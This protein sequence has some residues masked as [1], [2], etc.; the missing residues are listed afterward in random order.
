MF[1]HKKNHHNHN[2]NSR[3]CSPISA[4]G[5][6]TDKIPVAP[7]SADI[8]EIERMMIRQT[9]E[10]KF[11]TINYIYL[12]DNN[13]KLK[14]VI[15]VKELFRQ[16]K[17]K[18][19]ADLMAKELITAR[20][21]TSQERVSY[22]AMKNNIK[23]VPIIDKDDALLGVVSNDVITSIVY[24]ETNED[25]LRF[26]GIHRPRAMIDNVLELSTMQSLRH[27]FPWIFFG[28]LGGV[29]V[30]SIIGTFEEII[31]QNI[32][33]AA[34]IPL[35]VYMASAVGA[36]MEVFIVRDLA[37]SHKLDFARYF[38]RQLGVVFL[39]GLL[40]SATLYLM[41]LIFYKNAAVGFVLAVALLMAIISSVLTGLI[42]PYSLSKLRVDPANI[43]GP[44]ATIIQDALSVVIYFT[45]ASR[46]L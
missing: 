46:L 39:I 38:F 13:K 6:M 20:P 30:A 11:E 44:I 5:I 3:L 32:I 24:K 19:A 34:F 8:G 31:E 23:A 18:R 42:I 14:G 7:I 25:L 15:S 36:Q 1:N 27:R 10:G 45:I 12:V 16:P 4:C 2:N 43:S 37:I 33:L 40:S 9:K 41:C 17:N 35:V 26:A 28:L 22:L 29:A 21:H